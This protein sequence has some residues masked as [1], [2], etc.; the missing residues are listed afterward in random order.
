MS[1]AV[2][3][4]KSKKTADAADDAAGERESK[5]SKKRSAI[6]KSRELTVHLND[7]EGESMVVNC[8][9]TLSYGE[10]EK[11]VRK[12]FHERLGKSKATWAVFVVS[13]DSGGS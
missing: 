6:K 9:E 1:S 3:S 13:D 10:L 4:K 8:S 12:H 5:S 7:A 2:A 11:L